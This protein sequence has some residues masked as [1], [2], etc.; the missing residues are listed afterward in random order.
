MPEVPKPSMCEVSVSPL[1]VAEVTSRVYL[2]E[3][4]EEKDYGDKEEEESL[5]G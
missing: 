4:V 5:E 2:K 3:K 1:P